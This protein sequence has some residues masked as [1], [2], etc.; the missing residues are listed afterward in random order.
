VVEVVV[1]VL[2]VLSGDTIVHS[3]DAYGHLGDV[4][5]F[6]HRTSTFPFGGVT[7]YSHFTISYFN[8]ILNKVDVATLWP[9]AL[10]KLKIS[11]HQEGV[12]QMLRGQK[13]VAIALGPAGRCWVDRQASHS[14]RQQAACCR[15]SCLERPLI[16]QSWAT[17]DA[18]L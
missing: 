16:G 13:V 15:A 12:Q 10:T 9:F 18:P 3:V 7:T 8:I 11:A 17:F 2:V 4:E 1:V 5:V 6:T 14:C